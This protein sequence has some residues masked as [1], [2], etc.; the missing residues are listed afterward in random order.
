[1]SSIVYL[2]NKSSGKVY[3]YLNESVWNSTLKR[4]ECKRKCLGHVD[5]VTG[6][7]VPNK[8]NRKDTSSAFVSSFGLTYF[9]KGLSDR[10]GLTRALEVAFPQDWKLI[11]SCAFY[12]LDTDSDEL[13]RLTYWSKDNE[14][15]YGKPISADDISDMLSHISENDLF[16]FFREWRDNYERD[17]FYMSHVMSVSSYD[18]RVETIK[19]NDLPV[20]TI[21]PK[22]GLSIV[23]G[24][25]D[26]IPITYGLWNRPP[27]DNLDLGRR[28]RDKAWLDLER[29]VQVLD[30]EFCDDMNMDGLFKNGTRFI[31]RSPP[32]FY[33]AREAIVR[34]KDR[35]MAMDNL[36]VIEGEQL[37]V[38]SFLNYWKGRRCYTHIYFSIKEAESEF[39]YFLGLIDDCHRELENNVR[40][41]EHESFYRKY[42]N[43][44]ETQYGKIVEEDGEAIMTY[45]DVAGFFVLI[46]NSVKSPVAAYTLYHQ[47]DMVQREFENL[48]NE[49]DRTALKLYSETGYNG[50]LFVQ[51][52]ELILKTQISNGVRS[53]AL[54]RNMNVQDLLQEMKAVKKVSIPGFDTPFYTKINNI[55]AEIMKTFGID[56]VEFDPSTNRRFRQ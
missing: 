39:S 36:K 54:L 5:P 7:I 28:V 29:V 30:H 48:R 4:C 55:Q 17:D 43:V 16:R 8:G 25:K 21:T 24:Q 40:V 3:A 12:I 47:R 20:A 49:R 32:E 11:L 10:C 19:F 51:F 37:F 35:I 33:F 52:V 15:P 9:L 42:F 26:G 27:V 44:T 18:T 23:Y 41:R 2:K 6:D 53:N 22:T 31:V 34:V 38:M 46:S 56:P 50:R 45:N 13:S 1:M 14:N